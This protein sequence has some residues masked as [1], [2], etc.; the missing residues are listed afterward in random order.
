MEKIFD[1]LPYDLLEGVKFI[2]LFLGALGIGLALGALYY[3][4]IYDAN[5]IEIA[6]LQKKK[7]GL[8]RTLK[9]YKAIVA[10]RVFVEQQL[11]LSRGELHAMKQQMPREKELPGLLKRVS[12]Y[13]EGLGLKVML[14][15]LEEG[16]VKDFYKQLPVKIQIQGNLWKTMDFFDGVQNLL[17]LVNFTYLDLTVKG[18]AKQISAKKQGKPVPT[19]Q[20]DFIAETYSYVDGAEDK[21][22]G[23][24]KKNNEAKAKK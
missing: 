7:T 8:E 5:Q 23:P 14:F 9:N 15:Q 4:T 22:A 11:A 21:L 20:T 12:A 3:F 13:A 6:S 1:K 16:A 10:K 24:K 2:Q 18:V 17:R 19:L